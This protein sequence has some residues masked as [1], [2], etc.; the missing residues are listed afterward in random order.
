LL[1]IHSSIK[2][3]NGVV[4]SPRHSLMS[5]DSTGAYFSAISASWNFDVGDNNRIIGIREAYQKL[6]AG[7]KLEEVINSVENASCQCKIIHWQ[8]T[9]GKV[10]TFY[11][12]NIAIEALKDSALL[13]LID[14]NSIL[15]KN[16]AEK[17]VM[18][19]N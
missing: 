5:F 11:L 10:E 6:G 1:S 19:R 7:G 2:N 8:K 13:L 12:K 3:K 17:L 4:E 16:P 18:E 14:E 9:D 15:P